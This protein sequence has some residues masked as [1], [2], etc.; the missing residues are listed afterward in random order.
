MALHA[1]LGLPD[2]RLGSTARTVSAVV[3][4]VAAIAVGVVLYSDR[5][6][7]R[8]APLIVLGALCVV[9]GVSGF[10]ARCQRATVMQRPRLQWSVWG[11]L[12]AAA[13]VVVVAVL[14]ALVDW[15]D[16]VF[17]ICVAGTVAVPM[18]LALGSLRRHP[19]RIDRLLVHT[20][21]LVGPRR[22]WWARSYLLVV[23]GLGRRPEGD[24]RTLLGLS[25]LAAA[26]AALVV[27]PGARAARPTSRP[28]ASTASGTRPTRCCGPSAAG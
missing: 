20:I 27:G 12:V 14:A 1:T 17:A 7:F 21:V 10:V 6:E 18:S 3:G 28:G 5:P 25:M 8:I 9:I 15:P 23:L 19:I 24:E 2:G 4:Y 16:H 11:A 22:A 13:V 26:L